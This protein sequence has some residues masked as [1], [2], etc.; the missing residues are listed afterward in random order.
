MQIRVQMYDAALQ[1]LCVRNKNAYI[2][3]TLETS[4]DPIYS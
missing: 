1:W 3:C 2:K 4:F